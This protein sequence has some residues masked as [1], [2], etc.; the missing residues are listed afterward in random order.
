MRRIPRAVTNAA[1]GVC[2]IRTAEGVATGFLVCARMR[3]E[4][5]FLLITAAHVLSRPKAT[6]GAEVTVH[7]GAAVSIAPRRLFL[8]D[9]MA[10]VTVCAVRSSEPV[11]PCIA[12]SDEMPGPTI[13]VAHHPRGRPLKLEQGRVVLE[14]G[15]PAFLHTVPTK[16]GSSGAPVLN[17]SGEV[18]GVHVASNVLSIPE[19]RNIPI[20][21]ASRITLVKR[22]LH[23]EQSILLSHPM[24]NSV[25]QCA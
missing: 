12:V 13:W 4:R 10:D 15:T 1:Q 18:V 20:F 6:Y 5:M 24:R 3:G 8:T 7:N 16:P 23:R 19:L 2:R 9:P 11:L 25:P 22:L 14:T 17:R 21:E